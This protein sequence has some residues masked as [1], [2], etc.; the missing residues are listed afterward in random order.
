MITFNMYIIINHHLI[1]N[2][3]PFYLKIVMPI[4]NLSESSF[5]LNA[6]IRN[7]TLST[8]SKCVFNLLN[9]LSSGG[10]LSVPDRIML[11]V[12]TKMQ[13][14]FSFQSLLSLLRIWPKYNPI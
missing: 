14:F 6:R 12:E 7:P 10:R 9:K 13:D 11:F 3:E 4:E 5:A 2:V 8:N 1:L